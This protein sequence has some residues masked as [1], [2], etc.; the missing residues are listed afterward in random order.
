M[1]DNVRQQI[2][3]LVANVYDLQKLRIG[4]GNRLVQNFYIRLGVNPS[5]SIK[6]VEGDDAKFINVLRKEYK[7]ITDAIAEDGGSVRK[8]VKEL[9]AKSD[10]PLRYIRDEMDYKL[11]E[12]YMMLL[13]AEENMVSVLDGYV[14]Q[15]SMWGSFFEGIK[16]CGT[17][18]S[19]VCI[20]YIDI[21]E[22]K[23]VSSLYRYCGLDTVQDTDKNGNRLYLRKTAEGEVLWG[24]YREAFRYVDDL[25]EEVSG[26]VEATGEY[27]ADGNELFKAKS[28]GRL[29]TKE[30]IYKNVD[31]V[32]CQVYV[33]DEDGT[34]WTGDVVVSEHG[35]RKGDT[36]MFK[37][38]DKDGETKMKRGLTYNP[39]L[40]T[41][42]MGVL[43]GCII[44]AKDPVY[45]K[46][47]YDYKA[48]LEKMK[49][50]DGYTAA[51]KNMM[52]QRYMIK[53]FLRNM[54]NTW[55]PIEGL[56]VFEPYEVA[57]LGNKPH[58]CS[59]DM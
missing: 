37:Y 16:G 55:R 21:R 22:A 52:A 51:R 17:L 6:Q 23:Y 41:K 42:L 56:T 39:V 49:K 5:E 10:D 2:R 35:R 40:K 31:G 47:Y 3:C 8:K 13:K 19:A 59:G 25:G 28:D 45:S 53:Q 4:A 20:A 33:N 29:C 44:K 54:Y 7:R 26:V 43:T 34:E 50:Y 30:L 57:V 24:R 38:V 9:N 11:M 36:E 27:D 48:R 32:D 58:K 46:I 1:D 14:K 15:H 18:M 12:S